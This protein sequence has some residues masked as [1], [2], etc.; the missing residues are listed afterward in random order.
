V[1]L[2][3]RTSIEKRLDTESLDMKT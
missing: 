3:K 2:T 1:S